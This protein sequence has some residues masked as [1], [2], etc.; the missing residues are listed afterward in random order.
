MTNLKKEIFDKISDIT[1]S[2][3]RRLQNLISE[4]IIKDNNVGFAIDI[5]NYDLEEAKSIRSVAIDKL[6][7]I[8]AISNVTVVLTGNNSNKI[9]NNNITKKNKQFIEN[10]KKVIL[11]TSCKGGVGKST[12]SSLI[13]QTIA[14][15]GHIVGIVDAD[16]Y[17]PSVPQMFDINQK[18]QI[19]DNKMLP[20]V[21]HGIQ[22]MSIGFL[23]DCEKSISWRGPM[24]SKAI[25][26]LLSLTAW[27]NVD[28][29]IID[30][31]PGTGDIHLA[32]LENYHIDSALIVTTPQVISKNDVTKAIDLYQKFD[33]S[34]L[35]IIENMSYFIDQ[36]GNKVEVFAGNAGESLSATHAIPLICKIPLLQAIS[37][38][39]DRGINL[40]D[41]IQIPI[42]KFLY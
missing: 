7:Q 42:T 30:M 34:I 29:L 15:D 41:I 33:L 1:F 27:A 40:A 17:G 26:K 31:P 11:V 4:I 18:P 35:G 3:G 21:A 38:A 28:Y 14:K 23:I 16:I 9:T 2:D 20:L 25:Y 6:K 24:V 22:I 19:I 32:I 36:Y 5:A 37:M 39:C 13:A 12:I 10:V 8:P